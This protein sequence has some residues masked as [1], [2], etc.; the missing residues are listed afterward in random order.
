[1]PPI[2]ATPLYYPTTQ[3]C[4]STTEEALGRTIYEGFQRVVIL[5]QQVRVT[6]VKWRQFLDDF[7]QGCVKSEDVSMLD[8]ITLT[9]PKCIPTDF[10]S[11]KWK[12][13][14][15]ITPRNSVRL[16]WNDACVR[17]HCRRTGNQ[18]FKCPAQ[19]T[20]AEQRSRRP[21]SLYKKFVSIKNASSMRNPHKG[22]REKNG[23]P[24]EVLIAIGIKVMVTWNVN[25][26]IDV[27][28]GARGVIVGIKLDP[29][30]APFDESTPIVTLTKLPIYI[31]V[32]LDRTRATALPGLDKGV[33]PIVPTSK[34]Y[35]IT[36]P[37]VQK[38]NQVKLIKRNVQRLQFPITPAYA[39]TDYRSQGQT[40]SAAIVDI[41]TPPRGQ[42][43]R[44][45]VYVALSR[46][47]GLENIRIL[48]DFD[49]TILKKPLEL[50]LKQEDE[51]L[52]ALNLETEQWWDEIKQK[53]E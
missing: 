31:L 7:R 38:D 49:R 41:A 13:C 23:L 17:Q 40:I 44:P 25:T 16:R 46:C 5:K 15:L 50:E 11:D 47:S 35:G 26:N 9:N 21:I 52:E 33:I 14:C 2:A 30:E 8:S 20:C 34:S 10:E 6:D 27:T 43:K 29:S 12:D 51:R 18:L 48:R 42:L 3:R 32:K 53:R 24:D 28:N 45:N 19:D 4:K 22:K 1:I 37:V 39:F 36:V